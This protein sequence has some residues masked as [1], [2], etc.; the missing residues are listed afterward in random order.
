MPL[1]LAELTQAASYLGAAFAMGFGAIG[2]ATGVG[3]TASRTTPGMARQRAVSGELLK[4]MLIG[5]AI[6]ESAGIFSLVIALVLVFGGA[7][8]TPEEGMAAI[9]AGLAMGL[10]AIGSGVGTGMVS[11]YAC[12]AVAR[13]PDVR[14]RVMGTMLISQ[15][16]ADSPGIFA[17]VISLFLVFQGFPGASVVKSAAL[18]GA[19]F[20]MGA[21]A[22]GPALGIGF[23]GGKACE[24]TGANSDVGP[25]ITRTMLIGMAVS[26]STSIYAFVVATL[27]IFVV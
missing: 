2:S 4:T 16:L 14:G 10:G 11:G 26:E 17:L 13:R 24:A 15:A 23:V 20:A 12:E 7:P 5:Q 1:T 18:L 19:G 6:S 27:L 22:I 3:Y 9:A 8:S 25:L 21:G